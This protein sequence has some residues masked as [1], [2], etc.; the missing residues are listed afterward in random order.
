VFYEEVFMA[1]FQDL[2]RLL[3]RF[4]G[5]TVPG[6]A[7]VIMKDGEPIYEGYAGYADIENRIPINEH[8]MFRQA[9]TTKLFTYVI[10]MMLFE[11][12]E[13]LLNEPLYEYLPEW[14][15]TKKFVIRPNG[16]IAVEP[17]ERPITIRD[18]LIMSCGLPYC[19]RPLSEPSANPTLNAM[20]EAMKPLCENG[21]IPTLREEVKAM[22]RVPVMFEP[23]THWMYG[24]G[25][26]IIGALVEVITG[27]SVR[28]NMRE[29][30]IEPL[31]LKD[32][33]TLLDEEMAKKLVANYRC[34]PDGKFEKLPPEM[35]A[36]LMKGSVPEGSR[37]NLIS[38]AKDFAVFMSMLANG[39]VY[40]GERF[41]GRKTIDLIRT[42]H[43]NE[44]QLRD[45]TNS[46]LA[47]Y[48]YGLGFRT[49]IDKAAGQHNGSI[50]AF[51]WTGG[52]GTWAEADPSEGVA[53]TYMHNMIPNKEEYH[54]LRVRAV[55]Y[56]CLE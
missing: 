8:S 2:D 27:K 11:Q 14:R 6:C 12:G 1:R 21:R 48:G 10:C 51:G 29:K 16:E 31:G 53:I 23:G 42:N 44:Q 43:L 19:M 15:D 7:C 55:A 47:G 22:S 25:S 38:S 13:F 9:S 36:T 34:T 32:T 45:F 41:I 28:Q 50:G 56:G 30:L 54:H 52:A 26:E 18:A 49:V 3:N 5:N 39:G 24:F 35:D 33:E 37:A 40:K 20:S 4:A 17:L 46:Y